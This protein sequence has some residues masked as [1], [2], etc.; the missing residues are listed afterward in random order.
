MVAA[1]VT[2]AAVAL[3]AITMRTVGE[4]E[5]R[6]QDEAAKVG[7]TR[8]QVRARG[9]QLSRTGEKHQGPLT[10]SKQQDKKTF[11]NKE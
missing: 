4:V 3:E 1:T 8:E 11:R 7:S 6:A 5:T 9:W 2:A 10:A